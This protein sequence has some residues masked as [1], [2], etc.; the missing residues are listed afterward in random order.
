MIHHVLTF[1]TSFQASPLV[2]ISRRMP[3]S[4]PI[5]AGFSVLCVLNS[6]DA[7]S[8]CCI[9]YAT[10]TMVISVGTTDYIEH[11]STRS[12]VNVCFVSTGTIGFC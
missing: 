12:D 8:G 4:T 11:G 3:T 2:D 10:R 5:T 9:R 1:C 6:S 7:S